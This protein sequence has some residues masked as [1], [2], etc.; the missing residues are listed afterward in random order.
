MFEI[1]PSI[2]SA[3]F[4]RLGEEIRAVEE[5]GAGILHFDVM[6]GQFVPNITIGLPVLKSVRKVTKLPIDCHLMIENPNR[7]AAQFVEAGAN[8]VSVHVEA[9]A[10]LHRTL[11]EIREDGGKAGV[12]VNPATSLACLEDALPFADFILLMSANPGFGGQ[13]FIPAS[14][15][16]LRRLREMIRARNLETRVEI[17]GGV[18]IGNIKKIV[19]SGAEIIV[20]GSAVFG[21]GSPAKGVRDLIEAGTNW[22]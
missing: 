12:A 20:A 16:K 4:A 8:M 1:A 13:K 11:T 21:A 22:V 15:D 5:G 7:Y 3:D 2:L 14:L 19:E 18:D 6:D 9:D 17:D 10:H